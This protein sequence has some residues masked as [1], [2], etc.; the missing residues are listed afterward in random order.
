MSRGLTAADRIATFVLG[1]LLLAS[2][3]AIVAWQLGYLDR[4]VT[5]GLDTTWV[6]QT[7]ASEWYPW[8]SAALGLVV[9]LTALWWLSA[10]LRTHRMG[11][12]TLDGS[13]MSGRFTVEPDSVAAAA[14]ASLTDSP[15]IVSAKGKAIIERGAPVMAISTVVAPSF[16][17][18]DA[19]PAAAE[20]RDHIRSAMD[21]PDLPVRVELNRV[22]AEGDRVRVQ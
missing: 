11:E 15:G 22:A 5:S 21:A 9:A 4:F 17:V 20:L 7:V 12:H 13:D 3:S 19:L 18:A 8:V 2:G 10:H 14:A 16:T 1:L 6:Q